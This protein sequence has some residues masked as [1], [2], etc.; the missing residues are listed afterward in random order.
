MRS[1][2]APSVLRR[3]LGAAALALALT[4]ASGCT[5]PTDAVA[6]ISVTAD[7]HLLG[8]MMVCGHRIDGASLYISET[9]GVS[10]T[11][12]H[13]TADRP[14]TRGLTT[15]P[16]DSPAPVPGWTTDKNPAPLHPRAPYAFY[17][18]TK[19]NSWSAATVSFTLADLAGLTPGDV[20]Y[21][22]PGAAVTVPLAEF[23]AKACRRG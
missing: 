23:E 1:A 3:L 13:W 6:G 7:G 8:V 2:T 14:L 5:V 21:E 11:V 10:P 20:R 4:S 22:T 18:W 15:W 9:P 19:D 16:L 12:G 17:G